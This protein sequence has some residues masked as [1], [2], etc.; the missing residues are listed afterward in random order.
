MRNSQHTTPQACSNWCGRWLPDRKSAGIGQLSLP[1]CPPHP[2]GGG[3]QQRF[4]RDVHQRERATGRLRRCE[5]PPPR[6]DSSRPLFLRGAAC[7]TVSSACRACAAYPMVH[8]NRFVGE[9]WGP[10]PSHG[11]AGG[12][13]RSLNA[14]MRSGRRRF[15]PPCR[16]G[17]EQLFPHNRGINV[18][19]THARYPESQRCT[20]L[21][22][23]PSASWCHRERVFCVVG[24]GVPE[25]VEHEGD[26]LRPSIRK[27]YQASTGGA[28]GQAL[29]RCA[30]DV[31]DELLYVVRFA[32]QWQL[33]PAH[34]SSSS[35]TPSR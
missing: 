17:R 13:S 35:G 20:L 7:A 18:C 14:G 32:A 8:I 19:V 6:N 28:A 11:I 15:A 34:R 31:A 1:R 9:P 29:N 33:Q 10:R 16:P 22:A 25:S 27:T 21:D 23:A 3:C 30:S 24:Q 4:R 5:P 12:D 2:H 26:G